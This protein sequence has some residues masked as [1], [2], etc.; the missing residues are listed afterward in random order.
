MVLILDTYTP[1]T[2]GNPHGAGSPSYDILD[3]HR[4]K[5]THTKRYTHK[6]MHINDT[7]RLTQRYIDTHTDIHTDAH[8]DIQKD[9]HT[10]I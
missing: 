9:S 3:T 7:E 1:P 5:D 8:T 4:P 10:D 2:L 6:S